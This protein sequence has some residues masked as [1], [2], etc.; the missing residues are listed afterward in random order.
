MA[1]PM[2][3]FS[4]FEKLL[5]LK[6]LLGGIQNEQDTI[7]SF[8]IGNL[9]L[10]DCIKCKSEERYFTTFMYVIVI[11]FVHI[12]DTLILCYILPTSLI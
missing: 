5:Y 4:F 9:I 7:T 2:D 3:N 12:S 1:A 6:S 8:N 10:E 11:R